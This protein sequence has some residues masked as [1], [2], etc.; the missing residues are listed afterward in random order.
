MARARD[1][2]EVLRAATD[3]VMR[4]GGPTPEELAEAR[5]MVERAVEDGA[6]ETLLRDFDFTAG[7]WL[8]SEPLESGSDDRDPNEDRDAW[9]YQDEDMPPPDA[10]DLDLDR[11][12]QMGRLAKAKREKK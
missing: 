8:H 5:A 2:L 1:P 6:D 9:D 7:E 10:H 3:I 12:L 11:S 4:S